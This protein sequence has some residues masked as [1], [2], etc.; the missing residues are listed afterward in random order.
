MIHNRLLGI[1]NDIYI[2]NNMIN[3]NNINN[4]KIKK[5]TL[6]FILISSYGVYLTK[7]RYMG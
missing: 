5:H 1:Y 2:Y 6:P 7:L 4:K 3:N